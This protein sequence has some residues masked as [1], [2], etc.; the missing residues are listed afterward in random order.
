MHLTY[1]EVP[2]PDDPEDVVG[3]AVGI[4]DSGGVVGMDGESV[5]GLGGA[6]G[7][8]YCV[9]GDIAG[10]DDDVDDDDDE[11]DDGKMQEPEPIQNSEE[12]IN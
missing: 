12:H 8:E 4:D 5:V 3:G 9:G 6:V 10:V 7:V 11:D 2:P 1:P